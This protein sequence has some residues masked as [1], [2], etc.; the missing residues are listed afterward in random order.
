MCCKH[1]VVTAYNYISGLIK[2]Y[3]SLISRTKCKY[4]RIMQKMNTTK[5]LLRIQ[6]GKIMRSIIIIDFFAFLS[7]MPI[8]AFDAARKNIICMLSFYVNAFVFTVGIVRARQRYAISIDLIYWIFMYFF[9]FFAPLIQYLL[10]KF[11]WN[12]RISETEIL[13]SNAIIFVFVLL[14]L[15]GK[16]ISKETSKRRKSGFLTSKLQFSRRIAV[17]MTFI[18]CVLAFYTIFKAGL[19]GIVASRDQA[20]K[21]FYSGSNTSIRL[22]VESVIPAFM[23]YVTAEAAQKVSNKS[24]KPLRFFV[25]CLCIIIG[26]FPTAIPRYKMATI[27]GTIAVIAFPQIKKKD[28][29]FWLFVIALFLVFP[30]FNA[31][32]REISLDKFLS[33]FGNGVLSTYTNPDYDA[34]RMLVSSLRYV[35]DE[36]CAWGYQALGAFLFFVP[37]GIWPSKPVGSGSILIRNEFGNDYFSNVS[38]PLV[39]EGYINFGLVGVALFG[40]LFGLFVEKTDS[41]YWEDN[42]NFENKFSPYYFLIFQIFFLLRGDFLSGIAYTLAFVLMGLVLKKISEIS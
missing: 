37:R 18:C 17:L 36:G 3:A 38:C 25:L 20:T 10:N 31:F 6:K 39:A 22:I 19:H 24:E 12:G 41:V 5:K 32:R 26:F 11:P 40:F 33:T 14:Y 35:K 16:Q 30:V 29:F 7:L 9:M 15:L 8:V 23:A 28:R 34:Y 2:K 1:K 21:V 27:Y 4:L 13:Q 42:R